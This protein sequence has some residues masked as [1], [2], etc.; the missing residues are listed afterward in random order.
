M[1]LGRTLIGCPTALFGPY[2]VLGP[3]SQA[4]RLFLEHRL[5]GSVADILAS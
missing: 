2:D 1:L 4:D 3:L 5:V